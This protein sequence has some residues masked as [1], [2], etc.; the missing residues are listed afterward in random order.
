MPAIEPEKCV[1]RSLQVFLSDPLILRPRR[2]T[3]ICSGEETGAA[4]ESL[5]FHARS[6][7]PEVSAL[8]PAPGGA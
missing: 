1:C 4:L 8:N 5:L 6:S 3:W 2:G 7:T